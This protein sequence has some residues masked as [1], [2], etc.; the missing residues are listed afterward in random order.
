MIGHVFV[1][2]MLA[3][4]P[5]LLFYIHSKW[6]TSERTGTRGSEHFP[7]ALL[8]TFPAGESAPDSKASSPGVQTVQQGLL[9]GTEGEGSH[10]HIR[11]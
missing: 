4:Q 8:C 7:P 1:A 9:V 10:V 6:E 2:Q 11:V 5:I 3:L